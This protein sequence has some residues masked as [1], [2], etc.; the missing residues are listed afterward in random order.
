MPA[1]MDSPYRNAMPNIYVQGLEREQAR[2]LSRLATDYFEAELGTLREHV[3]V[4]HQEVELFCD[5]VEAPQPV[6]VRVSWIRRPREVFR[7]VAEGL[8]KVVR[9]GLGLGDRA[10]QI[11]LHEKWDDASVDGRLLSEWAAE[12]RG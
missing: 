9:E 10:V 3:F 2:E 6:I 12:N 7:R 11:E 8:T 4:F 5:G 1:Y